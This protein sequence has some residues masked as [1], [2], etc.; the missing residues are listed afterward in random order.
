MSVE[1]YMEDFRALYDDF[2]ALMVVR[3]FVCIYIEDFRALYDDLSL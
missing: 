1:G 3:L 2:V